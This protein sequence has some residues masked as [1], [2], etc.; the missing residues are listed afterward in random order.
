MD[1]P[2]PTSTRTAPPSGSRTGRA[3]DESHG[4]QEA[5]RQTL[6]VRL[7][8]AAATVESELVNALIAL[9]AGGITATVDNLAGPLSSEEEN[10]FSW[11]LR[12]ASTNVVKHSGA[13]QCRI[14][15]RREDGR[16]AL[17]VT[18]DGRGADGPV[19]LGSG[20]R[21][22]RERAELAGGRST[23]EATPD[24]FRTLV[25]LPAE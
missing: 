8:L 25:E 10:V 4:G 6:A 18:D 20:L 7:M 19:R 22:I 23:I 16:V 17:E 9:R 5:D 2:T 12:E 21:G 14:L 13:R 24:G 1:S 3:E 11:A 15:L